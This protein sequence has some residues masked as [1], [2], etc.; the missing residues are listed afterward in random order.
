[1]VTIKDIAK[2][3][4]VSYSTVSRALRGVPGTHAG[5]RERILRVAEEMGYEPNAIARSLVTN[6]SYTLAFVLPDLANPFFAEILQAAEREADERGYQLL[7]CETRWKA[8][9]ERR[10]V[11]MLSEKRVD[12]ILLYPSQ[13]WGAEAYMQ[14]RV[15]VV[16][17]GS[18]PQTEEL[19]DGLRFVE[20]DNATGTRLAIDHLVECGYER[21]A[22]IG[23]PPHSASHRCRR[24]NCRT[25]LQNRGR[26]LPRHWVL[27][28]SYTVES[29]YEMAGQMLALPED[30][31]PDA[32][33]C[34]N[35]MIALGA[36]ERLSEEGISVPE[37]MGVVG[38]DDVRYAALPQI[39]L[40]TVRIPCREW[41]KMA[42]KLLLMEVEDTQAEAFPAG[43]KLVLQPA[44]IPRKTTARLR[45]A[46]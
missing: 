42:M 9:K 25:Q 2:S 46:R 31:R 10:E 24:D 22:Y 39:Q 5:T 32:F 16:V 44:L 4:G 34:G 18:A 14:G 38:F 40:T 27:E 11:R 26:Q 1:M 30:Q 17:F 21:I 45:R 33:V 19:Q 29:G 7:I 12:G 37:Q 20:V 35:D 41:G 43:S 15:P 6:R 8:D 23:G 28:G 36:L 3:A 13:E